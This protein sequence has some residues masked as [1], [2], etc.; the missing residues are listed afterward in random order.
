MSKLNLRAR[1]AF[2]TL[3]VMLPGFRDD[4]LS[5]RLHRTMSLSSRL[6]WLILDVVVV[7]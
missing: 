2:Q 5:V 6:W 4:F 3:L 1:L 7:V